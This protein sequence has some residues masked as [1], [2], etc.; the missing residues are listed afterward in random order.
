MKPLPERPQDMGIAHIFVP[1][2]EMGGLGEN[3]IRG[4]EGEHGSAYP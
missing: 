2:D 3:L 1:G 4:E